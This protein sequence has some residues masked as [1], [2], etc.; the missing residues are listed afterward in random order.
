MVKGIVDAAEETHIHDEWTKKKFDEGKY[1]SSEIYGRPSDPALQKEY[2][3][4]LKTKLGPEAYERYQKR[5]AER[6]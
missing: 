4:Y 1:K 2:E 3:E 6:R 5:R